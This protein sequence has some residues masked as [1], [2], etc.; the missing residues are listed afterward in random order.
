MK[1]LRITQQEVS[2]HRHIR[3]ISNHRRRRFPAA[4]GEAAAYEGIINSSVD[5]ILTAIAAITIL[6]GYNNAISDYVVKRLTSHLGIAAAA[7]IVD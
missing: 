4:M 6:I 5:F 1:V 3:R 7:K 2:T